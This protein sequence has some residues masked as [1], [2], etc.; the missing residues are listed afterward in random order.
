MV[1]DNTNNESELTIRDLYPH[2][3]KEELEEAEQKK[4]ERYLEVVLIIYERIEKGPC[5][6]RPFEG[7]P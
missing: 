2:L 6:L 1:E 3:S 5:C 4:S 7:I